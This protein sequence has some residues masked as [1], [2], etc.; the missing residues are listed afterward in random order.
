[1]VDSDGEFLLIE[2]ADELP[3]WATP[4]TCHNRVFIMNGAVHAVQDKQKT[5]I[6]ILNTVHQRS[7]IFK[8]SDKVCIFI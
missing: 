3:V 4:E 6:N 2:A 7:H 5:C 8:L 1:M